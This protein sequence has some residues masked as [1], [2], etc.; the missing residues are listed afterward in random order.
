LDFLIT[1]EINTNFQTRTIVVC[2][3]ETR[4]NKILGNPKSNSNEPTLVWF[5][6][7]QTMRFHD[8]FSGPIALF[9]SNPIAINNNPIS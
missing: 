4:R 9:F 8:S 2:V 3:T 6:W 1:I 5:V 7:F